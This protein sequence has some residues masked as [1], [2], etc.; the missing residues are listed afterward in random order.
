MPL[1]DV[2]SSKGSA[3]LVTL[4]GVLASL[5]NT[6]Q[7]HCLRNTRYERHDRLTF[8]FSSYQAPHEKEAQDFRSRK[9]TPR[10][11]LHRFDY[12]PTGEHAEEDAA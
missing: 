6:S 1:L 8:S 5:T 7:T 10:V 2:H 4:P 9:G 3:L 12:R 11:Q